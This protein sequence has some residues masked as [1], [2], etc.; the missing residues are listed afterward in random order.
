MLVLEMSSKTYFNICTRQFLFLAEEVGEA[1]PAEEEEETEAA[2]EEEAPAE[3]EGE[4]PAEEEEGDEAKPSKKKGKPCG[5][6]GTIGL[7]CSED[8]SK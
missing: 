5:E 8:P 7:P 4:A 2:E 6:L 3:E 1:P